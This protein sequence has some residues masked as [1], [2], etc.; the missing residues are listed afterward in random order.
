MISSGRTRFVAE[1]QLAVSTVDAYGRRTAQYITG[2][3]LR[4]DIREGMP[5]EQ[6]YVDG[7]A[8]IANYELR[9]RWPNIARI[10]I[11]A[12]SRIIVRDK[13]LRITGIRNLDQANRVAIIDC[14]EVA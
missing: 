9:T 7:V 12:L 8:V 5:S 13:T 4:V 2:A 11:N 1:V 6:P 10:G 3:S 14:V